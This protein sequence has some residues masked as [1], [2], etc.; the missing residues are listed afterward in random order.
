[1]GAPAG[2]AA[3]TSLAALQH[4]TLIDH[5]PAPVAEP[6]WEE[7]EAEPGA[8]TAAQQALLATTQV[9]PPSAFPALAAYKLTFPRGMQVGCSAGC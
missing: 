1:M 8:A 3:L 4:L 7:E 5:S 9:P 2:L 6:E